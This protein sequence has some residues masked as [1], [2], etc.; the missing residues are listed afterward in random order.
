[1]N[2][3]LE[4]RELTKD[5]P[6]FS[7]GPISISLEAGSI[8][9]FIG[10]NGA[11]KTT[12]LKSILNIVHPDGGEVRCFGMDFS[13]N[14][15][16]VK[17]RLGYAGGAV[18]WYPRRRIAE[19]LDVTRRFYDNWDETAN[20]K[21]MEAFS[22]DPTKTPRELSEGMR[23]K[24]NLAIALSHRAELLLL[25]EPTSGLDP[26]SRE[27]L[28]EIFLSLKDEGKTILFSTHITSDLD[29]CAGRILFLQK[30]RFTADSS[31]SAESS[32][33]ITFSA[34]SSFKK[35]ECARNLP[36][37]RC[38]TAP[39]THWPGADAKSPPRG[40]TRPFGRCCR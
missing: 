39:C 11:G 38:R 5:Y 8:L 21:Y 16:A 33:W 30:G 34:S 4:V 26:V 35:D 22:L 17:Q 37:P 29:K 18:D 1:M 12:T 36:S 3:I 10:R 28:I 25:D 31:L 13:K 40:R 19:L 24:L 27:E 20:R 32:S 7:L 9:G 15:R 23:V 14:E 2:P 6:K